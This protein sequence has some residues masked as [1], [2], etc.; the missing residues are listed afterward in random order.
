MRYPLIYPHSEEGWHPLIPLAEIN[1]ADNAN[2]HARHR[3]HIHSES[4]DD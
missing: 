3:T 1:L 4:D 2:L